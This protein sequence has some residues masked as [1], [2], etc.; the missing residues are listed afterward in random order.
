M[1]SRGWKS[2]IKVKQQATH[3][4]QQLGISPSSPTHPLATP[5]LPITSTRNTEAPHHLEIHPSVNFTSLQPFEPNRQ[6]HAQ[7]TILPPAPSSAALATPKLP[8]PR[9]TTVQAC[10][11]SSW[12]GMSSDGEKVKC[13]TSGQKGRQLA[14]GWYLSTQRREESLN[15]HD[16]QRWTTSEQTP[17]NLTNV[18][19]FHDDP[20]HGNLP[21]HQKHTSHT[22]PNTM[23][24]EHATDVR[25]PTFPSFPSPTRRRRVLD[26]E[27]E[28]RI[29][30]HFSS[31][32]GTL[33]LSG[34]LSNFPLASASGTTWDSGTRHQAPHDIPPVSVGKVQVEFTRKRRG[35][36]RDS[37]TGANKRQRPG[38]HV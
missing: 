12:H 1:G 11:V 7:R 3:D 19:S 9:I 31:H 21:D 32:L 10:R 27:V 33:S 14:G 34:L 23:Q 4:S 38:C 13:K 6:L 15:G 24:L 35:A 17:P 22:S 36:T 25:V 16:D 28:P 2:I 20:N 29:L 30:E 18:R 8:E 26:P 37:P 5:K